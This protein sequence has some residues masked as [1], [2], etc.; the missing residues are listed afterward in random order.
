MVLSV[1]FLQGGLT[2][3]TTEE[4]TGFENIHH[5]EYVKSIIKTN[6]KK[7]ID[8]QTVDGKVKDGVAQL[9]EISCQQN[10]DI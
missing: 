4:I 6:H 7:Y 8:S 3:A 9:I 10:Q 5:C 1:T 2:K